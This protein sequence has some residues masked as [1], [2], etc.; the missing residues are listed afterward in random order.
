MTRPRPGR[1]ILFDESRGTA[2]PIATF[3]RLPPM[4][5]GMTG[6]QLPAAAAGRAYHRSASPRGRAWQHTCARGR[7]GE[8]PHNHT[9]TDHSTAA[10]LRRQ[11][12][13]R[14]EFRHP[15]D[16]SARPH[17]QRME[18]RPPGGRILQQ[19][20]RR[21]GAAPCPAL[22]RG[23]LGC[24]DRSVASAAGG[25]HRH[26]RHRHCLAVAPHVGAVRT[27]SCGR[28]LDSMRHGGTIRVWAA[29]SEPGA[30]KRHAI[31]FC[32]I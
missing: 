5:T 25:P 27:A 20:C 1:S 9:V 30:T 23:T 3:G 13:R 18:S 11:C 31:A 29:R 4:L 10:Q 28:G 16:R 26:P 8:R 21:D 12:H 14:T 6:E 17:R 32:R 22:F 15:E 19:G 2:H 24:D 7:G